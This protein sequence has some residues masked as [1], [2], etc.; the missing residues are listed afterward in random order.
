[1]ATID[2]R[3]GKGGTA[4]RVQVRLRGHPSA[5]ATFDRL[6]DAKR[7]AAETEAAIRAGRYFA[8]AEARRH[9]FAE[10]VDRYLSDVLPGSTITR[11]SERHRILHWW[12]DELGALTLAD[13]TAE[14]IKAARDR[15]KNTITV[16]GKPMAPATVNQY[17]MALSSLLTEAV[18]EWGWLEDNPMR[19]VDKLTPPRGRTRFLSDAERDALLRECRPGSP[20]HA[21]VVVALATGARRGEI[22]GLRWADVDLARARVTFHETKNGETRAVPLS[23][24]ALAVLRAHSKVRRIGTDLVFPGKTDKPLE[25]G[26]MFEGACKRAGLENFTFHDLRHTAASWL[27]MNGA[28]LAEIAEVLGHKTLQMVKRYAH[29]T[30]GHTRGVLE[31]MAESKLTGA[32]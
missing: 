21:V 20:L 17:L 26:K 4:Y 30:E 16:R 19:K 8:Q 18:K 7:W 32:G 5:V 9:T 13:V 24:P 14:R 27:A 22:L 29:L 10:A 1:M 11:K 12:A 25:V 28:T 6:T 15:L 23:A 2:K 3:T 31:R